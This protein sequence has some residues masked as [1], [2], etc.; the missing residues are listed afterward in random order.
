MAINEV[1]LLKQ[2]I[3]QMKDTLASDMTML[4]STIPNG[5]K[6]ERILKQ[7]DTSLLEIKKDVQGVDRGLKYA[8]EQMDQLEQNLGIQRNQP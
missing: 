4:E 5:E 2:D 7:L 1:K 6:I 3:T 8:V